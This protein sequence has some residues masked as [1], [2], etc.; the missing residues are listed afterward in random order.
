MPCFKPDTGRSCVSGEILHVD[1]APALPVVAAGR[2]AGKAV[3][4][5]VTGWWPRGPSQKE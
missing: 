4:P 5:T 3:K 2:Q 1:A